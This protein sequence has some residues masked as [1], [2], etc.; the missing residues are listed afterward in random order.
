MHMIN[1]VSYENLIYYVP[2]AFQGLCEY[3]FGQSAYNET[4][5]KP[6]N[7][8]TNKMNNSLNSAEFHHIKIRGLF[9]LITYTALALES[10]INKI[11]NYY[12]RE[13]FTKKRE[14]ASAIKKW[15]NLFSEILKIDLDEEDFTLKQILNIMEERN[16]LSHDKPKVHFQGESIPHTVSEEFQALKHFDNFYKLHEHFKTL[17]LYDDGIKLI[18]H[19]ET[20]F[21]TDYYKQDW[22]TIQE[23]LPFHQGKFPSIELYRYFVRKQTGIEP[24]CILDDQTIKP[25]K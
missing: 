19:S 21:Y 22:Y 24:S 10:F 17:P 13:E 15:T 6:N 7:T 16:N 3:K 23:D 14:K 2:Y 11:G 5:K 12:L 4:K 1:H 18:S 25:A 8:Y 20:R 9:S